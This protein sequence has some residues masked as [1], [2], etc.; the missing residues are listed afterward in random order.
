MSELLA[1]FPGARE[2]LAARVEQAGQELQRAFSAWKADPT[3]AAVRR[4]EASQERLREWQR[5]ER[6]AEIARSLAWTF[7][8]GQ[9]APMRG[10]K[11]SR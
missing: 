10:A 11:R 3:D 1:D 7:T 4:L 2:Y 5:P 9:L 6:L 8:R